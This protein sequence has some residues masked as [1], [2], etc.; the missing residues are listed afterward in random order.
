MRKF[1]LVL[2]LGLAASGAAQ[3]QFV[4]DPARVK[5]GTYA[6]DPAHTQVLFSLSHLGLTTFYGTF[7]GASGTLTLDAKKPSDSTLSVSVPVAT[8]STQVPKL[9]AEL[10]QA[11][12]LDAA[13]Y[14]VMTFTATKVL[15]A[16]K[17]TAQVTGN[18]TLHGVTKPVTL[19][20]HFNAAGVNPIDRAY[21]VGF[22]ASGHISRSAFGV[23]KYVPLIGDDVTLTIS[24]AF[25]QK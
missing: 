16:H 5:G 6:I 25:E 20:V 18:L 7:S 21:S 9:D 12:W 2:A 15:P 11:D 24:A 1:G 13:K 14:P 17:N 8:V 4:T 22:E 23:N 10:K 19:T 3:A